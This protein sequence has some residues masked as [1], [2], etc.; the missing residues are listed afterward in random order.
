MS[1]CGEVEHRRD[2]FHSESN[3]VQG[4]PWIPINWT[5]TNDLIVQWSP[6]NGI[7]VKGIIRLMG[8]IFLRYPRPVWS[9]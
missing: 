6:L 9:Q 4:D 2:G 1:P 8:S 5:L 7:T 3:Q